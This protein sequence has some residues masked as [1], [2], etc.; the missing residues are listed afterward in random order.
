MNERA[1]GISISSNLI[2]VE[3]VGQGILTGR[4]T[5]LP[6]TVVAV[7]AQPGPAESLDEGTV[8]PGQR[9]LPVHGGTARVLHGTAQGLGEKLTLAAQL[10]ALLGVA[11]VAPSLSSPSGP[12]ARRMPSARPPTSPSPAS[13][14]QPGTTSGMARSDHR[15]PRG[16]GLHQHEAELLL[17]LEGASGGQHQHPGLRHQGGISWRGRGAT[18]S[19]KSRRAA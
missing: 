15:E 19:R 5:P 1:P 18:T 9:R 2:E 4:R 10:E 3:A 16:H 8:T 7:P 11:T 14:F 13:G 12:R 6:E 17:P